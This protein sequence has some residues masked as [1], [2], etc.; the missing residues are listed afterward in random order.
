MNYVRQ[1][2][3][4]VVLM[5]NVRGLMNVSRKLSTASEEVRNLDHVFHALSEC[6][7]TC[8]H[9]VVDPRRY[10]LPQT[11]ARVWIWA[12]L[13]GGQEAELEWPRLLKQMEANSPF[14]LEM[15]LAQ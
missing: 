7:Y 8:G 14:S 15:L 1:Q 2:K 10:L 5:E 4:S 11:R 3:P 13:D 9:T 6:G 12:Q